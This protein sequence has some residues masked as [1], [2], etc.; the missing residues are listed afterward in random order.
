[1]S[2]SLVLYP[3]AR[4]GRGLLGAVVL[5]G[6]VFGGPVWA[7]WST[8]HSMDLVLEVGA[9]Q[10]TAQARGASY[11]VGGSGLTGHPILNEGAAPA[12]GFNLAP[13]PGGAPFVFTM[14]V[15][16]ADTVT[17]VSLSGSV[18]GYA[19]VSVQMPGSAGNLAGSISGPT[20]GSAQGGGP[21]SRATLTQTTTVYPAGPDALRVSPSAS[22]GSGGRLSVVQSLTAF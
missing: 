22:S 16:P 2:L 8:T 18:P 5:G 10:G 13:Q 4:W 20:Q 15:T 6:G 11:A 1:M 3:V 19:Q 7:E 9:G 17:P 14:S 21:G 12:A